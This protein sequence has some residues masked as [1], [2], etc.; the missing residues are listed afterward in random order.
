[1]NERT[2]ALAGSMREV[3][4]DFLATAQSLS[5][6]EWQTA[7][8]AEGRTAGEIVYHLVDV[9]QRVRSFVH[10]LL[11]G[12]AFSPFPYAE[13]DD[14]NAAS[15]ERALSLSRDE[16]LAGYSAASRAFEELI[17]GASDDQLDKQGLA[18]SDSVP[19]S[20]EM[21][22]QALIVGHTSD[23]LKSIKKAIGKQT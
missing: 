3:A 5:D 2:E 7:C 10:S 23:H 16:I 20:I 4:D 6:E 14:I 1:M 8:E 22:M 19:F 11:G 13:V 9:N 15:K 17:G 21:A 12:P 18:F